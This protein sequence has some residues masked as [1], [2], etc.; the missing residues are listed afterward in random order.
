[1][2]LPLHI[3]KL[4]QDMLLGTK[5]P[6]SKM[7][8]S[9]V[10]KMLDDNVLE[11]QRLGSN[12]YLYFISNPKAVHLYLHSQLGIEDLEKYI[13]TLQKDNTTRAEL[14]QISSN[15]K[16]KSTKTFKGFLINCYHPI[17]ASLDNKTFVLHPN[18]GSYT[19]IHQFETFN[20]PPEITI[21]GIE[22]AE[23]FRLIEKQQYLFNH[24]QPLFIARYPQE[25]Y[26]SVI[27]WLQRIPNA[28]LHFGDFD[29]AGINIYLKEFKQHL[30][31]RATFFVPKNIEAL[32]QQNGNRV[33]YNQQIDIKLSLDNVNEPALSHLV[34]LI[35]QYKKGL[36]QEV[37]ISL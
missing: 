6:A 32:I 22:N 9:I 18:L 20:I 16:L 15:S 33:L 8:H 27:K 4:L 11:K 21:V 1:M 3:A 25:Q 24:L 36:E 28:Y 26:S 7:K 23:N 10:A 31:N 37:L 13:E 14:V 30:Q 17:E 2:N 12:K 35:H 19:F 34:T 5:M 29:L